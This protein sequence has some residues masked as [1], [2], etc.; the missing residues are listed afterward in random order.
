M[1]LPVKPGS[2][3]RSFQILTDFGIRLHHTKG[4]TPEIILSL[5][6]NMLTIQDLKKSGASHT[7]GCLLRLLRPRE[8][9]TT[10]GD[11]CHLVS[12]RS[13]CFAKKRRWHLPSRGRVELCERQSRSRPRGKKKTGNHL[14]GCLD[15]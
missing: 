1:L 13:K 5:I 11:L 10:P 12:V 6:S 15:V 14:N 8:R 4:E 3:Y 9:R 7:P 2:V